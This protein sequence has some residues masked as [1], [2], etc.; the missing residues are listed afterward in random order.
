MKAEELIGAIVIHTSYGSG[1]IMECVDNH[2]KVEFANM[3]KISIFVYPECFIK[4]LSLANHDIQER[5]QIY[6][7]EWKN[8][9]GYAEKEELRKRY[10]ATERGIIARREATEEKKRLA[11]ERAM[12]HR[13]TSNFNQFKKKVNS[14]KE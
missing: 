11:A 6:L 3:N 13:A 9:S 1:T 8:N 2:L 4:Y 12:A 14:K 7:E 5:M 10:K